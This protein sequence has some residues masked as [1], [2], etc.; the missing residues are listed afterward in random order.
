MRSQYTH[1]S[2]TKCQYQTKE[3]KNKKHENIAYIHV[4]THSPHLF[5]D[6]F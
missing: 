2:L 3:I 6:L 1:A 5:Q 4:C